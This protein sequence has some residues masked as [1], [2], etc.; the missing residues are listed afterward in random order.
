[1]SRCAIRRSQHQL[2]YKFYRNVIQ[3]NLHCQGQS[4]KRLKYHDPLV[5]LKFDQTQLP[6]C[7]V[8]YHRNVHIINKTR[9]CVRYA[10]RRFMIGDPLY[11]SC[12]T[13]NAWQWGCGLIKALNA[14]CL[15]CLCIRHCC[16]LLYN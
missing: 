11:S 1:M 6:M 2:R 12:D 8:F 7:L 16:V 10:S 5:K 3:I 4:L 13:C 14:M 9:L 15:R